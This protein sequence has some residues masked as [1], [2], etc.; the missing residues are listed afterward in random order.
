MVRLRLRYLTGDGFTLTADPDSIIEKINRGKQALESI[1]KPFFEAN[2]KPRSTALFVLVCL[3]VLNPGAPAYAYLDPGT[4]SML[5]Q[6]LLGGFAGVLVVGKLYWHRIK[7]FVGRD[8]EP[9]LNQDST[10]D[11][12]DK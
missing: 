2:M 7:A 12:D 6:L 3:S 8:P 1:H 4:G 9:S 5:L 11:I 10:A